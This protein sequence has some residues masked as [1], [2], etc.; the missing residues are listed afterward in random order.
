MLWRTL[1]MD[2]QLIVRALDTFVS[3]AP[4]RT[5]A[6]ARFL[7]GLSAALACVGSFAL[8]GGIYMWLEESY[9]MREALL[10]TGSGV[11]VFAGIMAGIVY[12]SCRLRQIKMRVGAKIFKRRV[13][14]LAEAVGEELTDPIREYPKT[15][16][17]LAVLAGIVLSE[18]FGDEGADA[19]K[20]LLDSHE[21]RGKS[22]FH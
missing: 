12:T 3:P 17:A 16:A 4:V 20:R 8:V 10:I 14:N 15:A 1:L 19:L 2:T 6:V 11:L 22:A 7:A 21:D 5:S 13:K 9:T 18:K